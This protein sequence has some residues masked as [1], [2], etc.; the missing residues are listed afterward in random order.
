MGFALPNPLKK[1]PWNVKKEQERNER[2]LRMDGAKLFRELGI[3]EDATFEEIQDATEKALMKLVSFC[4]VYMRLIV[5][6]LYSTM[7]VNHQ[8][9]IFY[10]KKTG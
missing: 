5:Y 9:N 6:C 2:K 7:Y 8:Y 10:N 4:D 1:L 3:S